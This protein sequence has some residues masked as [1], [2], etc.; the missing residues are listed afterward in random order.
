MVNNTQD[1]W[2]FGLCPSSGILKNTTFRKLDLFPFHTVKISKLILC[3]GFHGFGLLHK[4]STFFSILVSS[5][6]MLWYNLY[7]TISYYLLLTKLDLRVLYAIVILTN[8]P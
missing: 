7:C 3:V 8:S 2:V 1:Y 4:I 5:L 6:Y